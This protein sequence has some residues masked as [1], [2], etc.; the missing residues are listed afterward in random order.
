MKALI[1]V[2]VQKDF[3]EGGALA[4]KGGNALAKKL[5]DQ[6]MKLRISYD[7]VIFTR[8]WHID[9]GKHFS[10]TPDYVTTWPKHC[11]A[12]TD[13]AEIHPDAGWQLGDWTVDKGLYDE[14]YSGFS[15]PVLEDILKLKNVDTVHV[16][17]IARD[18]CVKATAEDAL[19]RGYTTQI[20]HDLSVGVND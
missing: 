10:I 19:Y 18:F 15:N 14:G 4:V 5:G 11:I 12:G 13:G 2:D 3:C 6:M 8:D 1:V 9:P 20:L 7:V 16:C 17:G